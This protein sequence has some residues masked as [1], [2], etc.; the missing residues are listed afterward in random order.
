MSEEDIWVT[1]QPYGKRVRVTRGTNIL[2]AAR[3][4]GVFIPSLCGGRGLC[5]KC[6]V[7]VSDESSLAKPDPSEAALLGADAGPFRLA[8]RAVPRASISVEIPP[9]SMASAPQIL[10]NGTDWEITIDPA[11][12]KFHLRLEPPTLEDPAADFERVRGALSKLGVEITEYGLQTL[13]DGPR[14]LRDSGWE[15]TATVWDS[16][17]LIRI[18][19]GDTSSSLYGVAVDVGTTT[20]VCQL[21]DLTTGKTVQSESILNPQIPYGED[22]VTRLSLSR[23]SPSDEQT[24]HKVLVEGIS[25]MIQNCCRRQG[26][27]PEDV[28][29][30]SVVGNTVMHHMAMGLPSSFLGESPFSPVMKRGIDLTARDVGL[31]LHPDTNIHAL[32]TL[33]GYVGADACAVILASRIYEEKETSM[34]IDIG[35]NGEIVLGSEAGLTTCSCAAGPALEGAHITFGMRASEG[36]IEKVRID[37]ERVVYETIGGGPP[38]GIC[39]S[40][41]I[42]AV[43]QMLLAGIIGREGRLR[44]HPR[45]RTRNGVKEFVLVEGKHT[46]MGRDIVVTQKD[47]REVQLAKAAIYTGASSLMDHTGNR[48]EDIQ[49]VYVAGAFGNYIDFR[50][51][52]TIGLIPDIPI[53][54][55]RFIGNAAIT[56]AKLS[57]ISRSSRQLAEHVAQKVRYVELTCTPGFNQRYMD[58]TYLPHRDPSRFPSVRL[59]D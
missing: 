47:I 20:V 26:I 57:L 11:V 24:L 35:T 22:I 25:S 9:E 41:V 38:V 16:R 36:A 7:K 18:Q 17:R 46:G 45:V 51:A 28:L 44:P 15:V 23:K 32:P 58:A 33:A 31:A 39:G 30:V 42:D 8:C 55:L 1:F 40:G 52:K 59:P 3:L 13:R 14:V 29:E 50:S 49:T 37:G 4:A 54:R 43:A 34:A 19:P 48:P 53:E 5:G 2:E 21:V 56:G 12:S 10:V 6:R 27:D